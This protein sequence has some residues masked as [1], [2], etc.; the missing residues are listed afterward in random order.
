MG[1]AFRSPA[2]HRSLLA[3]V[4]RRDPP[5]SLSDVARRASNRPVSVSCWVALCR[6]EPVA[7]GGGGEDVLL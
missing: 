3:D 6:G 7:D 4:T 5:G 2:S 1:V